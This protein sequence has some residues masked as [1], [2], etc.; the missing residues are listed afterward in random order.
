MKFQPK[1]GRGAV[2]IKLTKGSLGRFDGKTLSVG[3]GEIKGDTFLNRREFVLVMRKIIA[4]AK[5]NKIKSIAVSFTDLKSLAPKDMGDY[6]IGRVAGTAFVMAD[7]E[8][9]TY[10]TKPKE[11]WSLVEVAAILKSPEAAQKGFADGLIIATEVNATRE[12][13]NTPA[14]DLTPK[15]LTAAAKKAAEGTKIK[16]KSLGMKEMQKLGMGAIVGVGKGAQVEPE[17]IIMEYWGAAK[18]DKP[19]VLV[20]KG[21]TFDSGGLQA[22]GGDH[23]YEMHMD[24]SGGAAVIH[25]VV[26]A[27]KLKLKVN[28]VG[29]IPAV[30]NTTGPQSMRPGDILK[31][32]SGKTIEILHTDAEG[33]VIL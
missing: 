14:G 10:K 33:R 19:V 16:V 8:H 32:L 18:K 7:Y 26:L 25:S 12:L 11:G 4:T 28:V 27:T 31:S 29:L 24:M 22:K 9:N 13:A 30:E 1:A 5:A 3:Y 20:G 23:M 15:S 21:V 2:K 17:F 6:E